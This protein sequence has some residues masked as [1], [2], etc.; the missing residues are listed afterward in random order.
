MLVDLLHLFLAAPTQSPEGHD[1]PTAVAVVNDGVLQEVRRA[2]PVRSLVPRISERLTALQVRL[3]GLQGSLVTS[4]KGVL[5]V[6]WL[7]FLPAPQGGHRPRLSARD[8]AAGQRAR[9]K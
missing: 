3:H 1:L 8:P 2:A 6:G 7:A 5:Q 4:G 9:A